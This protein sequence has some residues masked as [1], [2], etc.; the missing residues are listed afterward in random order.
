L[1]YWNGR[2]WTEHVARSGQQFTDP[3]VA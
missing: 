2:E 3:P 1:R